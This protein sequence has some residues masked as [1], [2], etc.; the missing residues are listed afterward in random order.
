MIYGEHIQCDFPDGEGH[1]LRALAISALTVPDHG[2]CA[3]IGPSG[4]GKST[5]FRCLSGLLRPTA[6][7]ILIDGTDITALGSGEL[8]KWRAGRVGFIFQQ[9]LLLPYLTVMENILL[10]ADIAGLDRSQKRREA[11][12][13][14]ARLGME[15]FGRR[16]PGRLSGGEKQRAGFIRAILTAPQ[17]LLADEPTA[18]LDGDNSRLLMGC[19]LDYQRESGCTLLCATHDPAVQALFPAQI[20]LMKG[21]LAS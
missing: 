21:A 19:L 8:A 15:G 17:L 20:R 4:S 6:G 14:L 5:L 11:E 18:S 12:A 2:C 1:H 9:A 13:W 16:M 10:A 3:V 7:R